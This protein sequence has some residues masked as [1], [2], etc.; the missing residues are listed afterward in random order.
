MVKIIFGRKKK[1]TAVIDKPQITEIFK[2][3]QYYIPL[4]T[5]G[6]LWGYVPR[7]LN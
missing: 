5:A 2:L 7:K 6:D 4:Q 1:K 3:S